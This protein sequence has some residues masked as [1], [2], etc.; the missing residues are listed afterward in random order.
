MDQY[1]KEIHWDYKGV[2]ETYGWTQLEWNQT[3]ITKINQLSAIIFKKSSRGG[4]SLL[5]VGS[6]LEVL[7]DD[8]EYYN[9]DKNSLGGRYEVI[10]R[11]ELNNVIRISGQGKYEHRLV[12]QNHGPIF[13]RYDEL[14]ES[15]VDEEPT[16][17]EPI[18]NRR[19]LILWGR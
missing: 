5:E 2:V 3:I 10:F 8:L 11:P 6:N 12:I 13:D 17:I 18:I 16:I 4:G 7:F 19:L 15:M 14:I 9:S 1:P